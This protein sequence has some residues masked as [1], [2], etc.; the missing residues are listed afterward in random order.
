LIPISSSGQDV[1]NNPVVVVIKKCLDDLNEIGAKK[2]AVMA[3]G[4]A[5]HEN[6]NAVEE[7]M[8]V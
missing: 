3:E 7:L 6:L 8:K 1:S 4:V 5:M 2:D